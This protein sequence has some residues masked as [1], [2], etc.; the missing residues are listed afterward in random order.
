MHPKM[1]FKLFSVWVACF[2]LLP[3]LALAEEERKH[4]APE[5]LP[6]SLQLSWQ[7]NKPSLGKFGQCAAAFDSRTDVMQ[8]QRVCQ[9][10]FGEFFL[11]L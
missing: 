3:F 4:I 9:F 7:V 11:I 8:F 6:K 2:L 5:L 10:N 1:L